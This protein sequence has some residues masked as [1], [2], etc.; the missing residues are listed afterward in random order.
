MQATAG[1]R[2]HAKPGDPVTAGQPL[3][4]LYTE[5]PDEFGP[6]TDLLL[7]AV[8]TATAYTAPEVII[9]VIN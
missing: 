5:T 2:L 3:M 6:A 8:D 7:T 4:T 9:D 1:I